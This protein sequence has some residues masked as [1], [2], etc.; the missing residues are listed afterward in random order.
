M[1]LKVYT[2]KDNQWQEYVNPLLGMF[3]RNDYIIR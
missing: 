2:S 1:A 3:L